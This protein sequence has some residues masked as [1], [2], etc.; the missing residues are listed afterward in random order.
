MWKSKTTY[1]TLGLSLEEEIYELELD[2]KCTP[3]SNYPITI[4]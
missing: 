3:R 1:H 2:E 4:V